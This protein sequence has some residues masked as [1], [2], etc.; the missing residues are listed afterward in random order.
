[1]NRIILGVAALTILFVIVVSC[2]QS[3]EKKLIG[4]W[5]VA[6]VQT[7]FNEK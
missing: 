1:M 7:E 4:T 6:D 5:K 3:I 2:G